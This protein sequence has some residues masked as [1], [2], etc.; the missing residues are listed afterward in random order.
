MDDR[1]L[2]KDYTVLQNTVIHPISTLAIT[3]A[4]A[5]NETRLISRLERAAFEGVGADPGDVALGAEPA[6]PVPLVFDCPATLVAAAPK[7]AVA[8]SMAAAISDEADA[9]TRPL[10]QS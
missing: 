9:P 2:L 8:D 5:V 10:Y 6:G 7:L 4:T 1:F 3:P